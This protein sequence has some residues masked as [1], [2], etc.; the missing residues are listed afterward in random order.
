[1]DR[2]TC[3]A[4]GAVFLDAR[5]YVAHLWSH[6]RQRGEL[7][8]LEPNAFLAWSWDRTRGVSPVTLEDLVYELRAQEPELDAAALRRDYVR[9]AAKVR[10]N[11]R[12]GLGPWEGIA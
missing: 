7:A 6:R 3:R 8:P 9:L 11:Q 2:A 12:L 10:R 1:M 4:C 5:H